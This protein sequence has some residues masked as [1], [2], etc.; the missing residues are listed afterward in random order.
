[1]TTSPYDNLPSGYIDVEVAPEPPL[2]VETTPIKPPQITP[3]SPPPQ[4]STLKFKNLCG[5]YEYILPFEEAL[6]VPDTMADMQKV[7][8]AEG[9][10]SL[11]HPGKASYD[12]NDFLAGDITVYTVYRPV[13]TE[14][15]PAAGPA[16][17]NDCP[18]DV[19]KSVITFKTDKCWDAAEGD[20]FRTSVVIKSVSAEI[21]NERKFMVK[22]ELLIRMTAIADCETKVFKNAADHDIVTAGGSI[23]AT[24][25]DHETSDVIEIS[26]EI[27]VREGRPSPAK[28]LESVFDIV[29]NHRQITSGKLVINASIHS[30]IL[31]LGESDSGEK[32]LCFLTNKTDFTQFIVMDDNTDPNL[33]RL[34]FNGGDLKLTIENKDKFMLQGNVTTLICSYSNNEINTVQDAYHK[35][36]ELYFDMICSPLNFV[37]ETVSGEISAREVIDL[38][39]DDRRPAKLLCGSCCMP[40]IDTFQEKGRMVIEGS[41]PVKILAL[42][43]ENVPMMIEHSVPVRGAITMSI[44]SVEAQISSETPNICIDTTVKEFWFNEINS[45]Q[46]EINTALTITIWINEEARLCT[47]E[48]LG[49]TEEGAVQKKASMAIYVVGHGDTLWDVA[50]RY[51]MDEATIASINDLDPDNPLPEGAKLFL[52][53]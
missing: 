49:F 25:L 13:P 36:K 8:F 22:G 47:I 7:L 38:S 24:V 3:L 53:K 39:G 52:A 33:I 35:K 46:I 18:V 48:N 6:L 40:S 20:S 16:A 9:K 50:K 2:I 14:P 32:E 44:P 21:I 51:K 34:L 11:S 23:T 37:K 15:S 10:V 5:C 42:D 41:I 45:R 30:R 19:V 43:E 31:Y 28:I 17:Y 29:E 26:Q 4:Y 1:M 12:R 27:T